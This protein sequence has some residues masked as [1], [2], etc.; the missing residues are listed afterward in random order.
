MDIGANAITTVIV[1]ST[2][3]YIAEYSPIF[4]LIGGIVLALGVM[5]ALIDRFFGTNTNKLD[6][7][8]F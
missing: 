7:Q 3:S 1:G 8:E 5:G 4:L 2:T 6:E